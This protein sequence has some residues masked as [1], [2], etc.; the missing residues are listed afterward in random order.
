MEQISKTKTKQNIA[1]S[2]LIPRLLP[3]VEKRPWW[4]LVT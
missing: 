4:E 2:N 3:L 1:K